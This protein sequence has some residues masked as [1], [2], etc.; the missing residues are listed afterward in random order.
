MRS[1]LAR[2]DAPPR[3]PR[4]GVLRVE[5][6]QDVAEPPVRLFQDGDVLLGRTARKPAQARHRVIHA[7]VPGGWRFSHDPFGIMVLIFVWV[8]VSH[9]LYPPAGTLPSDADKSEACNGHSRGVPRGAA[10]PH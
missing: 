3:P 9:V 1:L 2:G 4:R 10:G 6:V 7:R 8:F 5:V